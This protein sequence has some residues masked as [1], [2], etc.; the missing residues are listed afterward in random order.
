V[1]VS[2]LEISGHKPLTVTT[3]CLVWIPKKNPEPDSAV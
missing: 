2:E 3:P 1:A